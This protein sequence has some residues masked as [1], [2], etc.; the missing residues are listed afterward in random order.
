MADRERGGATTGPVGDSPGEAPSVIPDKLPFARAASIIAVILL[1]GAL[2]GYDQGVI[3][4]ALIGIQKAFEVGHV[5]L[6]IVTSWVT[7]GAMFGSLAGGY[8]ADLFGRRRTLLAAAA[9]FIVGAL[10]QAFA[11]NVPILVVGRLVAGFGV[12]VAA[13]AAPLYA[14][15]LAPAAQRGR[16]VSSYQLAITVGIFL[17][18]LVDQAL[19]GPGGWRAMFAVSA[20]AGVLLALAVL[21]ALES[22]RWLVKSGRPDDARSNLVALGAENDA[23]ARLAAIKAAL[24]AEHETASWSD[25]FEPRWRTPLKI[26]LGLAVLQQI[27]GINAIIYYS[28]IIFAAAGFTTPAAQT[29]ATT[30]AIGA[31]NVLATFIAIAFI[32]HLG[33]RPLLIAG[34]IGMGLSL[35]A[36]GFAFQQSG[37]ATAGQGPTG[38]VT[39][40]AL[41]VFIISFAFSLGPVTWTVINEIYP[42]EVRGRA[43]AVATAVNWGAAFLVSGFFLSVVKAIG[44]GYTFWLFA[45]FCAIGLVWVIIGVPETRGRSLEEIEASW[46]QAPGAASALQKS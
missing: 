17:A 1:A 3:S 9:L 15:E 30:W 43:V 45:A 46:G 32:D 27:T 18:Y 42:G 35:T 40:V 22:P 38:V 6:E 5:A 7:L 25:V 13:V 2:F 14:A 12:G 41:V 44:Q 26:G 37:A 21:T 28:D 36:V 29:A 39:L 10:V 8:F 11:P 23:D 19:A 20:V 34:L 33:R 4:G 31:V 16:F 24:R